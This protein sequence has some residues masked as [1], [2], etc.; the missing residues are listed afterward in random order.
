MAGGLGPSEGPRTPECPPASQV[1]R[2]AHRQGDA[3]GG[4][5]EQRE[6]RDGTDW[7]GKADTLLRLL[8]EQGLTPTEIAAKTKPCAPPARPTDATIGFDVGAASQRFVAAL[9]RRPAKCR[10]AAF[11]LAALLQLSLSQH[12][13]I[14]L[15]RWRGKGAAGEAGVGQLSL[16]AALQEVE[17]VARRRVRKPQREPWLVFQAIRAHQ[18]AA[19]QQPSPATTTAMASAG[20][21][22]ATATAVGEGPPHLVA[23]PAQRA[24]CASSPLVKYTVQLLRWPRQHAEAAGAITQ[25]LCP[26]A[27]LMARARAAAVVTEVK[28]EAKLDVE[29]EADMGQPTALAIAPSVQ[30]WVG[31]QEDVQCAA[32]EALR[33]LVGADSRSVRSDR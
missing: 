26:D 3:R 25:L 20:V 24:G 30:W 33:A 22:V 11:H 31:G 4:E 7:L 29:A 32:L 27:P 28:A 12:D 10:D 16:A 15:R 14:E 13:G 9:L 21:S 2:V 19:L 6:G 18:A 17:A 8:R 23:S 1:G 5:G